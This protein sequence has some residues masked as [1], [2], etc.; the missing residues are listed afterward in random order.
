MN[1]KELFNLIKRNE[2][3]TKLI[4]SLENDPSKRG[5][6]FEKVSSVIIK[7]GFCPHFPKPDFTHLVGNINTGTLEEQPLKKF[8]DDLNVFSKM[9]GGSSDITC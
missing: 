8:M 7:F 2:T 3:L 4:N 1:G 6:V 5:N 9:N